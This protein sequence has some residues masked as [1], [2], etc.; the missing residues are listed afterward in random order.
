MRSPNVSNYVENSALAHPDKLALVFE[1]QGQWTF[2]ELNEK[3][4]QVA[5]GLV[6]LGVKKGDRVSLFLP[7]CAEAIFF[8]FGVMKMGGIVNPVNMMLKEKELGYIIEDCDPAVIVTAAEVIDAPLKVFGK[9][10]NKAKTMI[11]VNGGSTDNTIACEDW[12]DEH[13]RSFDPVSAGSGDLAAILYT[14]GTT[15]HPKGVMLTH[16]NLWVNARHCADWAETTYR[17]TGVASLPLFHSY[18]LS[19]VIGELWMSAGTIVWQKRFD[20]TLTL[21]AL[22][23]YKA[24]CFHGVATMYHA[25]VNHPRVDEYAKKIKLRYCVTGAAVT[26]EP[27]LK[28][29]NE[30]FTPLSEG[31]GTTEASPVVL[32][33]PLSGRSVQKANSCGIPIVSEIEVDVFDLDDKPAKTGDIGELVI[34]GPN[35]MKGY[36]GREDATKAAM[37]GGWYHSGDLACFDEDGYCFIK[38]RIKDMIV[39]GG[40]NIYP[41]E[42]EDLLYTHPSVAE[43]QVVGVKDLVKGEEVV[44]CIA[45][46]PGGK[47]TEQEVVQYC[48]DN[49]AAYKTPKFVLFLESLP[50]TV[51]GKLEKLTLRRTVD[52]KFDSSY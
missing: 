1:G 16:K 49:L 45:L 47:L 44:A 9:P 52:N 18:A 33:N 38:D 27:I 13:S 51:T 42:V 43:V 6:D 21:E 15:G 48:R 40:F 36:W 20:P 10:E 41:R 24:T 28:A 31:Y 4:N 34:R 26:P 32:M 17:D 50:K 29:W 8:Y 7:N 2:N 39:R 35:I 22:A 37:K 23:Q 3:I 5:N 14:S 19:H 46:K 25:L 30:K 11:V 12:L